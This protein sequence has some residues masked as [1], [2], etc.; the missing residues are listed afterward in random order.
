M[1]IDFLKLD[2][3][4]INILDDML[5]NLYSF[6]SEA[7][8]AKN[9]DVPKMLAPAS[10]EELFESLEI[11][12]V[13]EFATCSGL[14]MFYHAKEDA[15][16]SWSYATTIV[17]N[18]KKKIIQEFETEDKVHMTM[19]EFMG[20]LPDFPLENLH[21]SEIRRE[22]PLIPMDPKEIRPK[23]V[24]RLQKFLEQNFS[25]KFV[26]FRK[27][28][29][30]QPKV[31]IWIDRLLNQGKQ[32]EEDFDSEDDEESMDSSDRHST[33]ESHSDSS[34]SSSEMKW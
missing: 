4:N 13:R 33:D 7:D 25:S 31:S 34:S 19:Y 3:S 9:K 22:K 24:K 2:G 18:F 32:S 5:Y 15:L 20:L 1:N 26:V 30:Y 28:V 11:K 21:E 23:D 16:Y 29:F 14:D 6:K 27:H 8:R 17:E 10:S 12:T